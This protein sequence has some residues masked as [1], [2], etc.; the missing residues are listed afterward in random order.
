M[1]GVPGSTTLTIPSPL[2]TGFFSFWNC[3]GLD[4]SGLTMDMVRP[5]FSHGTV[6][7]LNKNNFTVTLS[8]PSVYTFPT[9]PQAAWLHQAQAILSYDSA[10]GRPLVNGEDIYALSPALALSVINTSTI[11]VEQPPWAPAM[12]MLG[13]EVIVRHQVYSFNAINVYS[14][15]GVTLRDLTVFT[16]PG[17]GFLLVS[18]VDILLDTVR[19]TK[20]PDLPMS[21]CADA[22]HMQCSR[23]FIIIRDSHFEGQG[24]DGLNIHGFFNEINATMASQGN[25]HR[26]MQGLTP[27]PLK[28]NQVVLD[29]NGR[30]PVSQRIF[31]GSLYEF[32]DRKSV[33]PYFT[34][35]L[36]AFAA[37]TNVASFDQALPAQAQ[38]RVCLGRSTPLVRDIVSV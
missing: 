35:R 8:N 18:C 26:A 7:A 25:E 22:V 15:T 27:T 17:M 37:S 31:V 32:R 10:T 34:A 24:D 28:S 23:G 16:I 30:G 9:T 33:Q 29:S 3:I 20:R 4:V 12:G 21:L 38:V 1:Q 5:G 6:T 14:S 36:V 2:L 19:I 13:T 11:V